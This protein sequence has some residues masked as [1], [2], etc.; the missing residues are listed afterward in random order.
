VKKANIQKITFL[1]FETFC[2]FWLRRRGLGG[3]GGAI[4][5]VLFVDFFG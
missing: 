5:V 2:F 4:F 3:L 1:D